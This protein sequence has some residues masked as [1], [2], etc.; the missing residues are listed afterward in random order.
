M[1]PFERGLLN[2]QSLINAQGRPELAAATAAVVSNYFPAPSSGLGYTTS[3][4]SVVDNALQPSATGTIEKLA[5]IVATAGETAMK[6]AEA[7]YQAKGK[8][9]DLKLISKGSS[10]TQGVEAVRK[11]GGENTS[12]TLFIVGAGLLAFMLLSRR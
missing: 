3:L 8:L 6:S 11:I 7:Y 10:Y 12:N 4:D 5:N 1:T 2:F 9:A